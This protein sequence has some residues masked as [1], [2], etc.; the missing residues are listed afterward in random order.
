MRILLL[1]F[2]FPTESSVEAI[3]VR[4]LAKFLLDRG[5]DLRVLCAVA[6]EKETGIDADRLISTGWN[7]SNGSIV[8]LLTR[9]KLKPARKPDPQIDWRKPAIEA[10]RALFQTW[11][12]DVIYAISPPHSVSMIAAEMSRDSGI[13]FVTEF[14]ERW[15]EVGGLGQ[16]DRR[17]QN[18]SNDF[19][20]FERRKSAPRPLSKRKQWDREKEHEI[21]TRAAAIVTTSPLWGESYAR[22]FG[23]S[24][25][26]VSLN[27]FDP[28]EY[29][30]HAPVAHGGERRLLHLLWTGSL[31]PA[32][33]DPRPIF[34]GIVALGEGAKDMRLSLI[35]EN[36]EA[37]MEIAEQERVHKLIDLF[38]PESRTD[39]IKRQFEADALMLPMLNV[40][41]VAGIA[42]ATLFD[43]IGTRRPVIASGYSK[44]VAA[45]IVRKRNLG[46]FSNEPKVIA[47]TLARLMA[48]KR[49]IGVVPFLPENVRENATAAAQFAA[50]EPMLYDVVGSAPLSIAAE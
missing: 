10:S 15:L 36:P 16:Y 25:V 2:E 29:P 42:P 47:N 41:S 6:P 5:H 12:A 44:G 34:Q 26:T 35:G 20:G 19:A 40:P 7:G 48:K 24:K 45:D 27:G 21:L 33:C 28:D 23:T 37:L 13:P 22:R 50:L 38:P 14:Q 30:L 49:A 31:D 8:P 32:H 39:T 11:Q 18:R 1:C 3:R 17:A 9:L 46:V 4:S 43:Y